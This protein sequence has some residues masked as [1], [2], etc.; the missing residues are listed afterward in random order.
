MIKKLKAITLTETLV[1]VAIFAIFM[2][3]LI[4]FFLSI[5][6]NQDKVSKELELEMNRIF[7]TNHLESELKNNFAFDSENSQLDGNNDVLFFKNENQ[8]LAYNVT[9]QDLMLQ[10]DGTQTKL[11]NN[12][13]K[14]KSFYITPIFQPENNITAV[15]I[16]ISLNHRDNERIEH[17]FT[18]LIKLANYEN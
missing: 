16:N 6:I 17:N 10:K 13:A 14:I 11:T 4:Q 18:T 12:K 5:Q 2:T 3:T 9:N 7:L 1:Y 8:T 15:K